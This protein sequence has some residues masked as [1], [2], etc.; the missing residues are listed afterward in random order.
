MKKIFSLLL[1][2]ITNI[3]TLNATIIVRLNPQSCTSWSTVRLWAW[4]SEGNL[5]NS[6]PGIVVDKDADGWYA[7]TFNESITSVNIIWND[8]ANQTVD[9]TNVT[10]STCYSLNSTSGTS[11]AVTT[12]DCP[13]SP[14]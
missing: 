10:A 5:F 2:V 14:I 12:I 13:N 8:G 3:C 6:W 9:I 1:V 7:Y 11:I 4:T